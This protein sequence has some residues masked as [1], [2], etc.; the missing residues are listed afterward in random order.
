MELD[1]VELEFEEEALN[2]IVDKAI[3]R[4]TGARGLTFNYR[5][6][7]ERYNVWKFTTKHKILE[8]V[9]KKGYMKKY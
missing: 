5:R 4:K 6:N 3:E 8:E 9:L 1:D 2:V 7:N